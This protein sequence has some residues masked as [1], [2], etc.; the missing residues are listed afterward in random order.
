MGLIGINI[1][2]KKGKQHTNAASLSRREYPPTVTKA[3]EWIATTTPSPPSGEGNS[4]MDTSALLDHTAADQKEKMEE[5]YLQIN[6]FQNLVCATQ[7]DEKSIQEAQTADTELLPLS[8]YLKKDTLPDTH[9]SEQ[10]KRLRVM[11][12]VTSMF[13]TMTT[14]CTISTTQEGKVWEQTGL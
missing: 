10:C 5:R 3:N 11:Q 12:K 6:A 8:D 1:V 2:H 9:T 7:A 4:I 14:P 13:L